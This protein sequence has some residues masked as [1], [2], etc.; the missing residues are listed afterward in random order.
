MIHKFQSICKERCI[1]IVFCID[2]TGSMG[3]CIDNVKAHAQ[4]L[5]EDLR[6]NLESAGCS[7]AMV[8]IRT[9]VFRDYKS[10]GADSM[11]QSRFFELPAEIEEFA[12]HFRSVSAFGGCDED[13]N[14]LEALY[15]AMKSEFVSGP[16]D[17]QIIVLFADTDAIPLRERKRYPGYPQEMADSDG[18][19]KLWYGKA[20][21]PVKLSERNKRLIMFAP[22]GTCYE[23]RKSVV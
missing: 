11:V 7:V 3:G 22:D 18:L 6:R 2:G 5:Y 19:A 9:I 1:D 21:R 14:G 23:D 16:Q 4:K 10:D 8:R 13:A 20:D 12:E 17:R 15:Y